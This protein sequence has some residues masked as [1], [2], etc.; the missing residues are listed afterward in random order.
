VSLEGEGSAGGWVW[1]CRVL[2]WPL[3][4]MAVQQLLLFAPLAA[5][6]YGAYMPLHVQRTIRTEVRVLN[7]QSSM[8][9]TDVGGA[10][11]VGLQEVGH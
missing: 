3:L 6:F 9:C 4:Y 5:V 8:P 2:A 11:E 1:L 10:A 7:K